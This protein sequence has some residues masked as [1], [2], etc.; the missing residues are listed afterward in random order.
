VPSNSSAN[1]KITP[2][3][4]SRKEFSLSFRGYNRQEVDEFL[5]TLSSDYESLVRENSSLK[6]EL[7]ALA[8]KLEDYRT[9]EENLRNSLLLAQKVAE[10]V[11][12]NAQKEAELIKSGAQMEAE[13]KLQETNRKIEEMRILYHRLRA[14]IKALLTSFLEILDRTET[15]GGSADTI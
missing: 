13:K 10:E 14:E 9:M 12:S 8:Q 1:L 15:Q 4:L 11:K 3:D 2:L 5:S 7:S 6:E